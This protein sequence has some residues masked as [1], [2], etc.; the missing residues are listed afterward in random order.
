M[1]GGIN[2]NQDLVQKVS[3]PESTP[4]PSSN[5]FIETL[6][7]VASRILGLFSSSNQSQ[8]INERKAV[9]LRDLNTAIG[10]EDD[11]KRM[12]E[13][14]SNDVKNTNLSSEDRAYLEETLKFF[15]KV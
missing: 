10:T 11:L 15:S 2:S 5:A 12:A 8:V 13:E 6:K 3:T 4:A 14:I 9:L 7:G 1:L